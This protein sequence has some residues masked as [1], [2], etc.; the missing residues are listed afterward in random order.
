MCVGLGLV[1]LA[2]QPTFVLQVLVL[3]RTQFVLQNLLPL[4]QRLQTVAED[5]TLLP[6]AANKPMYHKH[7][8]SITAAL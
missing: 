8:S 3:Q 1:Q 2:F 6:G 7:D 4:L 5:Q